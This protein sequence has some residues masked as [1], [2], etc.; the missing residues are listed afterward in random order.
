SGIALAGETVVLDQDH[1]LAEP[2]LDERLIARETLT[3]LWDEIRALPLPQR[4][5]LLLHLRDDRGN[6]TIPLLVFTGTATLD[7]IAAALQ[8]DLA[9]MEELWDELPLPD[10][11]IASMLETT[12]ARVVGLRRAA[13][14]RLG[15]MLRRR[16]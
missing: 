6:S 16:G 8:I 13:R 9:R 5:A 7:E 10:L 3:A 1:A 4:T 12:A 14:E 11:E 15:R 2:D